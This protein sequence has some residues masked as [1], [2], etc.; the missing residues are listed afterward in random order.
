M[1][2]QKYLEQ[3]FLRFPGIGPRQAK[4]FVYHLINQ[5]D[6]YIRDFINSISEMK[7]SSHR[8]ELCQRLYIDEHNTKMQTKR[9]GICS[10]QDRDIA[11]LMILSKESDLENVEKSSAY[12]GLYFVIGGM[13]PLMETEYDKYIRLSKLIH[14]IKTDQNIHEIIISLSLNREGE[15]TASVLRNEIKKINTSIRIYE[16]GRGL[17]TGSEIEYADASTIESAL[18]NKI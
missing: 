14:R 8:C 7:K 1:E 11:S 12:K 17:S 2:K 13:I 16:L 9:C 15:N 6:S 18:K 10:S 4:R 3:F 5:S